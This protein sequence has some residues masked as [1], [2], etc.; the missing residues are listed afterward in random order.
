MALLVLAMAGTGIKHI[1]DSVTTIFVVDGSDSMAR[2]K[3]PAEEFVRKALDKKRPQDNAGVVHYGLNAEVEV[4]PSW[5]PVFHSLQ[6]PVNGSFTNIER[7]LSLL[8]R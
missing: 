4:T 1:S 6:T 3:E 7:V 2:S 8:H 5:D